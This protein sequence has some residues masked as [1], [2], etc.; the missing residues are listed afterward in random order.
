V[1]ELT[2]NPVAAGLAASVTMGY[3][4]VG[5]PAGCSSTG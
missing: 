3:L 4:L 5:L 1:L 2:S